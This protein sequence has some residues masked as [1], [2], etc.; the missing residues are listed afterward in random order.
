MKHGTHLS[1]GTSGNVEKI[2]EFFFAAS[3]KTF[4][5]IIHHRNSSPFNL[6]FERKIFVILENP[7]YIS[8]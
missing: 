7:V 4:S 5:Y 2:L 6:T 1:A 3:S 8:S